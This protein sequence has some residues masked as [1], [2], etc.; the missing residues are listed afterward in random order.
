MKIITK[1]VQALL[2]KDHFWQTIYLEVKKKKKPKNLRKDK[3][4]MLVFQV[5]MC[6]DK[7]Q[8]F[9]GGYLTILSFNTYLTQIQNEC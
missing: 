4:Q 9:N 6:S 5:M 7:S 2:H 1:E 8:C 3:D